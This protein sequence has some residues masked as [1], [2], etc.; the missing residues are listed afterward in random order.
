MY[1]QIS[2]Y[3]RQQSVQYVHTWYL[4]MYSML[5]IHI[6]MYIQYICKSS[7]S[8]AR[9]CVAFHAHMDLDRGYTVGQL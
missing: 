4:Y 7:A 9:V 1:A 3:F 2:G 8:W 5:Y 6:C